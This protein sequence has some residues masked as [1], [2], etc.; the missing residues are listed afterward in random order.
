MHKICHRIVSAAVTVLLLLLSTS[1]SA[2]AKQQRVGS[3]A[4][5]SGQTALYVHNASNIGVY[6]ILTVNSPLSI[7]NI[8]VNGSYNWTTP[9]GP[10]LPVPPTTSLY[11]TCPL[12]PQLTQGF[13]Y[14][15][16]GAKISVTSNLPGNVLDGVSIA[17]LQPPDTCPGSTS[18][19][20]P[21]GA[22]PQITATNG[23]NFAEVTLNV[24]TNET[25]DISCNNGANAKI[26][27][28]SVGGPSWVL[29]GNSMPAFSATN[30]WVN[31]TTGEDN[32][33]NIGGVFPYQFTV[34]T[35]GPNA[36]P[37][38]AANATCTSGSPNN[39]PCEFTRPSGQSGGD[40]Y[41][42]FIGPEHPPL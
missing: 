24:T 11:Y 37:N 9:P 28:S 1:L 15:R 30:S 10:P 25:V 21:Y 38:N 29:N 3:G 6:C 12:C 14:M 8:G 35:A 26:N 40:V 13:F 42:R 19:F 5:A 2:G 39:G 27:I 41:V 32:N 17:F 36:C 23:T 33:C 34:C 18:G 7:T 20:Y 4:H 22:Q 31:G 16:K